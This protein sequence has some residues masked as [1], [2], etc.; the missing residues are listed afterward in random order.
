MAAPLHVKGLALGQGVPAV[1][2]PIAAPDEA[3]T[4]TQVRE[5]CEQ[6]ADIVE[7]R[8][9]FS[10][11]QHDENALSA[12]CALIRAQAG[13]V[14]LLF[15][16]RT[17]D[18]GGQAD[19]PLERAFSLIG[20]IIAHR[21]ADIVDIQ[22]CGDVQQV[23]QLA[24]K[25]REAGI[26]VLVSHHDTAG[27]PSPANLRHLMQ[28]MQQ[29][30]AH[31]VKVATTARDAR[32]ALRLAAAACVYA[33][34]Q[35]AVPLCAIAMGEDGSLCRVLGQAFGSAI[36]FAALGDSTA[37]GQLSLAQTSAFVRKVDEALSQGRF[38]ELA[39]INLLRPQ[40]QL[41][42]LLGQPVS[43]SLSPAIHNLSFALEGLDAFYAAAD[44][45]VSQLPD[46]LAAFA[47]NPAWV[48][49]N[50]TMPCKQEV[51][52]HLDGLDDA[53][54]LAGSVNTIAKVG[55]RLRGYNTDGVGFVASLRQA[56]ADVA[57]RRVCILGA[58]GAGSAV[59]AQCAL[60]GARSVT[61]V[62]RRASA[63]MGMARN[64][65]SSLAQEV[66][67]TT[68]LADYDD[69]VQTTSAIASCDVLV[70]ATPLGMGE[71]ASIPVPAHLLRPGMVVADLVY[72]P[73]RTPLIRAAEAA[74]CVA[75]P[76]L[77]MLLCQ[78]AAS[79]RIW[80]DMD[81]RQEAIAA[82]LFS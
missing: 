65:L 73:L 82:E 39:A 11:C 77:G 59:A 6:G 32:D 62:L 61:L 34:S 24:A 2:V 54:A 44:C 1:A 28:S 27:T 5:A 36:T 9:D 40:C 17:R 4:M 21:A 13:Q 31:I 78:A 37:P 19:M 72:H 14:P 20:A 80:F 46:A 43:H 45:A 33:R 12:R 30:G 41:V 8:A 42:A 57:G 69:P 58:G 15:T 71:D 53:A 56:G 18:Q 49:C 7:W 70:N 47:A 50:V 25:A 16:L 35:D 23:R 64:L 63:R 79:E 76:G 3:T 10:D 66:G 38:T 48:G 51:I 81:M 26:F 22:F 29:S 74:G 60:D 52:R 68:A 55:G 67:C 75:M